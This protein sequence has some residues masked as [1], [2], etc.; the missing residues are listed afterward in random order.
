[1]DTSGD[2][3][4]SIVLYIVVLTLFVQVGFRLLPASKPF[5]LVAAILTIAIGVPSL[6][7]FVWPTIYDVLHRDPT[8]TLHDGQ[9]W[10]VLTS[11]MAQDGGLSAA[12]FN[13]VVIVLVTVLSEWIWGR[14]RTV[15]FFILTSLI[16][17]LLAIAWNQPGGGS[18]FA[19]DGLLMSLCGF[20]LVSSR[21]LVIRLC[22]IVAIV[23]GI[24]LVA[25]GDAH[26]VAMLL[27]AASGIVLGY[28][29]VRRNA[30]A[31][32]SPSADLA[33]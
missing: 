27:G 13:L 11:V 4:L 25:L 9:W 19:S 10:R 33:R 20:G 5:P 26:G 23:I 2:G 12:I 14:W 8:L 21:R 1:M 24:V 17:N 3:I 28:V 6:L 22:A 32:L 29:D 15:L 18:S 31:E 30:S 16:L 7:Q